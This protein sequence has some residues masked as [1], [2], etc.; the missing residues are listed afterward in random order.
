M[1]IRSFGS[2]ITFA[3]LAVVAVLALA[4]SLEGI[5]PKTTV[6]VHPEAIHSLDRPA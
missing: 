5:E 4:G 6:L 1:A 3:A 2:E